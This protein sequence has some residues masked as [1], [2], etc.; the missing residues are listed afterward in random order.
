MRTELIILYVL[1]VNL[2]LLLLSLVFGGGRCHTVLKCKALSCCRRYR[3]INLKDKSE[4]ELTKLEWKDQGKI[5]HESD[6][7][8]DTIEH[9]VSPDGSRKT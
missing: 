1:I 3:R 4:T 9:E 8:Y 6:V 7:D 5:R 2:Y